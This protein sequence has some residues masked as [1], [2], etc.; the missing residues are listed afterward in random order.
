MKTIWKHFKKLTIHDWK[1]LIF[2]NY[3]IIPIIL[4]VLSLFNSIFL[5]LFFTSIILFIY[6]NQNECVV[7]HIPNS[8]WPNLSA[9]IY[10]YIVFYK[11]CLKQ[12]V[13]I[14]VSYK[15]SDM[16]L[17]FLNEEISDV[18]KV[19]G[20]R[21]D[22]DLD[23]NKENNY[24]LIVGYSLPKYIISNYNPEICLYERLNKEISVSHESVEKWSNYDDKIL[25]FKVKL[26]RFPEGNYPAFPWAGGN[27]L[28]KV[29]MK[30]RFSV[31]PL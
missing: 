14:T 20:Y 25:N 16:D 3:E 9:I 17:Y 11:I 21:S 1:A 10:S 6:Q 15:K 22:P 2:N 26:E 27:T 31:K 29:D 13:V 7:K 18:R 23:D 12:N 24:E 8:Q 30:Y 5:I 4:L 19:F 28:N